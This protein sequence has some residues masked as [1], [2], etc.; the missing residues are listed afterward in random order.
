M[1]VKDAVGRLMLDCSSLQARV[2]SEPLYLFAMDEDVP[3]P[4]SGEHLPDDGAACKRAAQI[5]RKMN[6]NREPQSNP[7]RV[8][9]YRENGSPV[10]LTPAGEES[11]QNRPKH[12]VF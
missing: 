1:H 7:I 9:P 10:Q 8:K 3:L 4:E 11:A 5:S 12:K 2:P 6:R